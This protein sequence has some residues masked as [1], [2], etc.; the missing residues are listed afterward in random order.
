MAAAPHILICD[1]DPVVHESLGIYLENEHFTYS[2]AYDG[3]EGLAHVISDK[4]DLIILDLMMPE[5]TG[6]EV[7]REIRKT[8]STPIIILTAKGEEIDRVLGLELGADDYIVKPFS[9][10]EVIARIKAVLR[11][12]SEPQESGSV[13]RFEGLEINLD[14]YQVKVYN[15]PVSCTPKEVEILHLLASHLGQVMDRDQILSLVWGHDYYG[16]TRT[17]DTHIKRIRQKICYE[18][19]RWSL[20]TV[21]GVGYKFEV[22]T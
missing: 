3:K 10:R 2:S 21:Y 5:K 1:D 9:P 6:I 11:R 15:E 17:V 7:C 18:G 4:P 20:I 13:L 16:D 12:I 14:N 19:A 8:L 22:S